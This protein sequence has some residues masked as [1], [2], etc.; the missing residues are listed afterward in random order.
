MINAGASGS[1]GADGD[2]A[3]FL[4]AQIRDA[5]LMNTRGTRIPH[6]YTQYDGTKRNTVRRNISANWLKRCTERPACRRAR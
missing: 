2:Q 4:A 1:G 5:C 3:V 6:E